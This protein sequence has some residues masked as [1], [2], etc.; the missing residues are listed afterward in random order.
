MARSMWGRS[1]MTELMP[2]EGARPCKEC[3]EMPYGLTLAG[4]LT[5]FHVKND[6]EYSEEGPRWCFGL[7]PIEHWNMVYG[8][9][10]S[11]AA[12][13][14]AVEG[15]LSSEWWAREPS[16]AFPELTPEQ[17]ASILPP[18]KT[19][20]PW[21]AGRGP[22]PKRETFT[23]LCKRLAPHVPQA[24][25]AGHPET[26]ALHTEAQAVLDQQTTALRVWQANRNLWKACRKFGCTASSKIG[27]DEGWGHDLTCP[28][29]NGLQYYG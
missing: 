10:S 12:Y 1:I 23:K 20:E 4:N 17:A 13:K 26:E 24:L 18:K 19:P 8:K 21:E 9:P 25:D 27:I 11:D 16:V 29:R 2:L 22:K 15:L 3:G 14:A 7:S 6:C 5:M 28:S